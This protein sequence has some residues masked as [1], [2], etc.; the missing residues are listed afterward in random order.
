MDVI[1]NGYRVHVPGKVIPMKS[2]AYRAVDVNGVDVGACLRER[3]AKQLC[4][5]VW[6]SSKESI[7]CTLRW[8]VDDFDRPWRAGNPSEVGRLAE[9]L[10]EVG[11][12]RRLVVA[13]E[14]TGTYGDALRQAL[15]WHGVAVH[16]VSPK[17]C[18]GLCGGV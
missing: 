17:R 7:F 9:L 1:G 13:M 8:S 12:G 4:M 16:R 2:R 15:G 10:A 14:S 5:R 18:L 11:R 6:I 3:G